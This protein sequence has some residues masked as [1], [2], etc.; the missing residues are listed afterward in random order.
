MTD[1]PSKNFDTEE[2]EEKLQSILNRIGFQMTELANNLNL[3]HS[4]DPVRLDLS[5]LTVVIDREERPIPLERMGSGENWVAYHLIAH[6]ALHK[7]FTQHNRPIPRFLIL[8]QPTQVYYPMDK[9]SDLEGSLESLADEDREAVRK[10]FNLILTVVRELFPNFQ[11]IITDHA[12]LVDEQFQD[13]VIER[14]RGD[15]ALIPKDW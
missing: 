15:N 14:W 10:M 8:D 3:E 13:A 11:V 4:G 7:Y 6:L 9:D 5:K 12:D 1:F 2:K